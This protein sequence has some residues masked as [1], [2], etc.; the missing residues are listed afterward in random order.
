MARGLI[1]QRLNHDEGIWIDAKCINQDD[2]IEKSHAIGE[3]DMIYKSARK[4]VIVLEDITLANSDKLLLEEMIAGVVD[5]K[6]TLPQEHARPLVSI[7]VRILNARW[8]Q[9][10]WCSHEFQLGTPSTFL[11]PTHST[12]MELSAESL[13]VLYSWTSDFT[14]ADEEYSELVA[15]CYR[16]YEFFTRA[17]DATSG[18]RS[19][20]SLMSEFSDVSSL[21]C[22][23]EADKISIAL[24]VAGLQLQLRD[25]GRITSREACRFALAMIALSTDDASVL[26]GDGDR[27]MISGAAA[28]LWL[29][30]PD[31]GE[32]Y[33]TTIGISHAEITK[34]IARVTPEEIEL[35]LLLIRNHV[36]HFANNSLYQA[37]RH[38]ITVF[39]DQ[40]QNWSRDDRPFMFTK[41]ADEDDES[42]D[43]EYVAEILACS[44]EC[45]IAW[46]S[47]QMSCCKALS[48]KAQERLAHIGIEFRDF[49]RE[50]LEI[51]SPGSTDG[52]S[53]I[54][55]EQFDSVSQFVYLFV[56]NSLLDWG[57]ESN[58]PPANNGPSS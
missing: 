16:S 10:A 30:W 21:D 15:S 9:R 3:M 34:S 28:N 54:S 8:F 39:A 47:N 49:V 26:C 35:D 45:G 32:D 1:D 19:N 33:L 36:P 46:I 42:K 55:D 37:V 5:E 24:N 14:L 48:D 23:V 2:P 43:R 12:Y 13:E 53:T 51:S 22:S 38:L 41:L 31:D 6:W 7:L 17:L 52:P 40:T 58:Y 4:I 50:L 20:R 44:L 57:S 27:L 56:M 25:D 11:I 18:T 29:H